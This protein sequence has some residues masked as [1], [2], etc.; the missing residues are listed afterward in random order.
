M[1]TAGAAG[2]LAIAGNCSRIGAGRPFPLSAAV[3]AARA[4]PTA[5]AAAA[6]GAWW[7]AGAP[8][9]ANRPHCVVTIIVAV[10]D[11]NISPS[12]STGSSGT[13][14]CGG[15]RVRHWHH[16]LGLG[17]EGPQAAH[18]AIMIHWHGLAPPRKQVHVVH[19]RLRNMREQEEEA[20]INRVPASCRW[21]SRSGGR[22]GGA[23]PVL[24]PL[25]TSTSSS[26]ASLL[27]SRAARCAAW[28]ARRDA[29]CC[30]QCRAWSTSI[31]SYHDR[32]EFTR[33]HLQQRQQE[34]RSRRPQ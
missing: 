22:R 33:S 18:L 9:A 17:V 27:A 23:A 4:L 1:A 25:L 14:R 10:I 34:P 32:Y 16:G 2:A 26:L 28:V 3:R 24:S 6:T 12:S 5:A 20:A 21:S 7:Q 11:N 30:C 29:I 19:E 13:A 31:P 15:C 8:R